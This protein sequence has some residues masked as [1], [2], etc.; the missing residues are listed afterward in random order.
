VGAAGRRQRRRAAPAAARRLHAGT[1]VN[2][3][4]ETP[5]LSACCRRA[6]AS[7][8]VAGEKGIGRFQV[9]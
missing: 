4:L 3:N 5:V 1:F 8:L 6:A 2:D 7:L 9:L